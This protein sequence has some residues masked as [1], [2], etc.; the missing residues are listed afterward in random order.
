[1]QRK[2]DSNEIIKYLQKQPEIDPHTYDGSYMLLQE[3]VKAYA[4]MTD[5]SV[6][7]YHDLNLVYLM[8]VGTWRHSVERKYEAI[9]ASH[10]P[11][12]EKGSLGV[13]LHMVWG[14]SNVGGYQHNEV[15]GQYHFGMFGTGF[16]SFQ[17]KT[18]NQAV[19]DFIQ[20][21]IDIFAM[22]DDDQIYH[23]AEELFKNGMPG[24]RAAAASIVLHGL[25][26]FVFPILNANMG[27]DNI[28][29]ALGIELKNKEEIR[30]YI[31]NCRLIRDFRNEH[32]KFKNYRVFDVAQHDMDRFILSRTDVEKQKEEMEEPVMGKKYTRYWLYA[33]GQGAEAWD[34]CLEKGIMVLGWDAV[35][36]FRDYQSK[37]E[38][39]QRMKEVYDP[40]RPYTNDALATWQFAYEIK[41]GDIVFVKKGL[42]KTLGMGIVES[43]Y[44]YDEKRSRYKHVRGVNWTHDGVWDHPGQ[45]VQKTLTDITKY[46][47]YVKKLIALINGEEIETDP[48]EKWVE[49]DQLEDADT[50]RYWWLNANPKIWS[51]AD[52]KVEEE[53]DYTLYNDNGNKRRIFQNFLDAKAGD[54][55]IGYESTPVKK[56]VALAEITKEQDGESLHFKKTESLANQIDYQMLKE[57]KEL[58]NMEYFRNAQGSLFRLT[59][60]EYDCIMD[61]IRESNPVPKGKGIEHYTKEDFLNDVFMSERDYDALTSL[62]E[63]KSNLI[64]QGAPGVGKTFAA[65]RLAWSMMGEKDESR[66]ETIQFHQ[67]Y[68]YEDFMMGY[69]PTD[70]GFELKYGI[71]YQFC[72]KASNNPSKPYFLLIDEINRGNMS[73]IFGE[74]LMLIE[75]DY[76]GTK[77]TLAYNGMPFSVPKN[78]YIIG[79]MNT[80]DRS[81]AMI[82]YALRRRFSFFTMKPGFETEGFKSYQET[83]NSEKLN[84]LISEIVLLNKEITKDK[85]LGEGFCIG[86]SYFCNHIGEKTESWLKEVVLYDIIPTLQEYW[87]D[88]A[89]NVRKWSD[90][91]IG[92]VNG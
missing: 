58:E 41:P 81:L 33:P 73:K 37:D 48:D 42:W 56:I 60:E 65:K 64:L 47:D 30:T 76:R 62:L 87:F 71:F 43:D 89:E 82:D 46:P 57:C 63:H 74:L 45:A 75:K 29:E 85:S 16:Y 24:M 38:M 17:S 15:N 25:K 13:V 59:E 88:D 67:N 72:T 69:K 86:H 50:N 12:K 61:L 26:P 39:K 14:T 18:N 6:L 66:I 54:R 21:L 19:R 23:R 77:A 68:S 83:I 2:F 53:Q 4:S 8:M 36:D 92:I 90:N 3:T 84:K 44:Y 80:A 9:R 34:E 28:F 91:L 52:I 49:E 5:L 70:E 35:G 22:E 32:F 1:M 31:Q 79:M 11:E 27:T 10:L 40:S 55:V 78:L 20:M 51:F 7:D